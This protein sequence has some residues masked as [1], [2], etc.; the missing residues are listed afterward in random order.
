LP[1]LPVE[2]GQ[3]KPPLHRD[4]PR[5]GAHNHEV[6]TE[7]GLDAATVDSLIKEGVLSG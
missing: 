3:T 5:A 6:L 7:I 4:V 1:R 2:F